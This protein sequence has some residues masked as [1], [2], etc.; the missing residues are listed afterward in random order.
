MSVNAAAGL[1]LASVLFTSIALEPFG[2]EQSSATERP[3]AQLQPRRAAGAASVA[4]TVVNDEG[5]PLSRARVTLRSALLPEPRVLV[6]DGMARFSFDRLPAGD[7]ELSFIRTGYALSHASGGPA[8]AVAVRLREGETRTGLSIALRRAAIIPGRL[9][10]EDGTPL[11]GAEIEAL[12]LRT[13]DGR[14]S[15]S[16]VAAARSDDRGEFRL[17]GLPAGQYVVLAR[18]PAFNVVGDETGALRYAPTYYPGAALA[19]DA[20]PVTVTEG[21]ESSQLEFRLRLAHPAR[22]AGT[23]LPKDRRPLLSGAVILLPRDATLATALPSEDVEILPDGRFTFRNVAPGRYQI[24]ARA[25]IGAKEPMLFGT[26]A[27]VVDLHDVVNIAMPLAPG[28]SLHGTLEWD[29]TSAAPPRNPSGL[30]VRAPF[31]DGSSFGDSLTGEVTAPGSFAIR[32]GMPGAHYIAVEGLRQPWAVIAV[33]L[34]GRNVIDQPTELIEGETL[35][36]VRIV[37][38]AS[39]GEV[40]GSVRDKSGQPAEDALVMTLPP[41]T[42]LSSPASPRFRTTRT[43]KDGKYRVGGLP[44][45]DYRVAAVSGIDE[46]VA[47]RREWLDRVGTAATPFNVVGKDVRTLD[48]TAIDAATMVSTVTR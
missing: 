17:T 29:P 34:R 13:A 38:S 10:D 42:H 1:L 25:E 30:R 4:G 45:G 16:V 36:D 19:T 39:T 23:M 3:T 5:G 11:A 40:S 9:L 18:D 21:R 8:R 20:Q 22:L 14:Q 24:R 35:R 46:L 41:S 7:Y 27:V 43:D 48:L 15:T 28:A 26:Y 47:Q 12:S 33:H 31:A 37:V 2:S 32:G 6:T 44:A